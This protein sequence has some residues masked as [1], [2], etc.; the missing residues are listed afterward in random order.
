MGLFSH[1]VCFSCWWTVD[2]FVKLHI[3]HLT[4]QL[5]Q[6]Y[7]SYTVTTWADDGAARQYHTGC[8]AH[9]YNGDFSGVSCFYQLSHRKTNIS[10]R[11]I[12]PP[13]HLR[14]ADFL[15]DSSLDLFS[16]WPPP[17]LQNLGTVAPSKQ[18]L[19]LHVSCRSNTCT[20]STAEAAVAFIPIL[21]IDNG[22]TR[23]FKSLVS[24]F[25]E[26]IRFLNSER[27]RPLLYLIHMWLSYSAS[28]YEAIHI[29]I[30]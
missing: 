20:S 14:N 30:R 3:I 17:L 5:W 4:E 27:E 1:Y 16:C 25:V 10:C 23:V 29:H 9:H 12:G 7:L 15:C 24:H 26:R 18:K 21:R 8:I 28:F 6:N 13:P 19:G 11:W 22:R 2:R